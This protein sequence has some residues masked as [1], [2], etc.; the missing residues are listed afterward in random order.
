MTK[1]FGHT[2]ETTTSWI[3]D[4]QKVTIE[5]S[6][7]EGLLPKN[8]RHNLLPAETTIVSRIPSTSRTAISWLDIDPKLT[9]LNCCRSCFA[10]YPLHNTPSHCR[11]MLDIVP[12]YLSKLHDLTGAP[13][14]TISSPSNSREAV[15]CGT[16]LFK[17]SRGQ[18]VPGRKYAFQSLSD[19]IARLLSRPG[20]E[21]LLDE[22]LE[23]SRKPH[24][25]EDDVPDIHS[26]RIWKAFQGPDG[27]QFTATSG[28]LTFAMFL[29]GINP[30]GIKASGKKVSDTFVI[31]VCLTLPFSIRNNPENTFL[32]GIAP[33]PDEPSL[34]QV[35]WILRPIVA[36]LKSLWNPG[37][38][39]SRTHRHPHGR[40][41]RAALLPFVA[42]LMAMRR[43]IGLPSPSANRL[44]SCCLLTKDQINNLNP[45]TWPRRTS[46]EHNFWAFKA[47]EAKTSA[48]RINI[49]Q[50]HGI[51][52]SVLVELDY[53][54]LTD[55]HVVDSMHNLLLGL[56][57][58]HCRAFWAMQDEGP[59]TDEQGATDK[60]L[61]DLA[62][63]AEILIEQCDEIGYP[64]EPKETISDVESEISDDLPEISFG[65][66]TSSGDQEYDPDEDGWRG[67]WVAPEDVVFD[68]K[69]LKYINNLLQDI[70]IPTWIKRAIPF[71]GKASFGKLKAD[72]W[73]TLF[74]I[75]LPLILIPLWYGADEVNS[76]LLKN[77]LHLVSLVNLGLKRTT[78]SD[79]ICR[80]R[81]HL[82]KYLEGCLQLFPHS[83]LVPNHHMAWHVADNLENFGPVRSW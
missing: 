79:I 27:K 77:F 75:Q 83:D 50:E 25:P 52:Y 68:V 47:A 30:F 55:Y 45:K 49:F 9:T 72:E 58:R 60:E 63:Q 10:M 22:S 48:E 76:S 69:M 71:L 38:H 14:S 43:S 28:N 1:I 56:L 24:I 18:L 20:L 3:L 54:R 6:L 78:N 67:R 74:T 19:W 21:D 64:A 8:Q 39:L 62:T 32:V 65:E 61:L 51:R 17:M 53:W 73:R 57:A 12:G 66:D 26:S 4:M 70:H 37:L 46:A 44:C 34:E 11:H 13:L 81:D 16:P 5:L 42:D 59:S 36:Q 41:I 35:N 7:T 2:S 33:G 15:T 40:V 31:M 80:Y 29:D 23:E 82:Q